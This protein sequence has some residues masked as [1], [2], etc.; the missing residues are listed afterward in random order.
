MLD[1]VSIL[2]P[3]YNAEK[4]IRETVE[5]ALAQTWPRKEIIVVD[6][7][8]SDHT[9][10]ILGRFAS[11]SVQIITQDNMGAPAARNT[12]LSIARGAFIQWLDHDDVL[13]PDKILNQLRSGECNADSRVLLSGVCGK[14]FYRTTSAQY[15][16]NA[17][18][19]DLDPIDYFLIKFGENSF[20]HPSCWL[21]SRKLTDMAGPWL[22][23]KSPDDDGEYFSRVVAAC[24]RIKFI[25]TAKSYWRVGNSKSMSENRSHEALEA[26]LVSQR[27]CIQHCLWLENSERTRAACLRFL[28]AGINNYYPGETTILEGANEIAK[29]LGGALRPPILNWKYAPIRLLF[30]WGTALRAQR[31]LPKLKESVYRSH[32]K[33]LRDLSI[34]V[35]DIRDRRKA[36]RVATVDDRQ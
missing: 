23:M 5:S 35:G 36:K 9:S 18:W 24:A 28:Q 29:Q 11:E 34:V 15:T 17:L 20:L 25:P 33:L 14:F 12:A 16:P 26:L 19:K 3:A 13:A 30:G 4:W 10:Q 27:R 31:L 1:L 8:S 6:D 7:G 32:D 21:V 22:E 2:I